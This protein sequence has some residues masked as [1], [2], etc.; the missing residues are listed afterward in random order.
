[1]KPKRTGG[2][3]ALL[4]DD[5]KHLAVLAYEPEKLTELVPKQAKYELQAHELKAIATRKV[6]DAKLRLG[7]LEAAVALQSFNE[8]VKPQAAIDCRV[9]TDANVI[10]VRSELARLEYEE[11]LLKGLVYAWK[12]RGSSQDLSAQLHFQ[13]VRAR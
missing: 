3:R 10:A 13:M 1:M 5:R 9:D 8:G 7:S 11:E 6:A 4:P 12:Q 2:I